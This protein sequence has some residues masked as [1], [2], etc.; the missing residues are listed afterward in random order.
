MTS[1]DSFSLFNFFLKTKVFDTVSYQVPVG[2]LKVWKLG[3]ILQGGSMKIIF[4]QTFQNRRYWP[5][6]I[7]KISNY[8]QYKELLKE[9]KFT[10]KL[11]CFQ[12]LR[13][14]SISRRE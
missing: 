8:W 13:H 6:P 3:T 14:I 1:Q 7:F 2:N 9:D 12:S 10:C 4:L 5:I 11:F